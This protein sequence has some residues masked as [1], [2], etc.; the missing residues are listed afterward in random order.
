[1]SSVRSLSKWIFA[2]FGNADAHGS[3]ETRGTC[4]AA[5]QL[6]VYYRYLPTTQTKAAK[7]ETSGAEEDKSKGKKSKDIDVEVDI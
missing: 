1:M 5:L 6:M 3:G 7:A 2:R 4:L